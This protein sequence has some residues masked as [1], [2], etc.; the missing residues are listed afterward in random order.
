[1]L[2]LTALNGRKAVAWL[3]VRKGADVVVKDKDR[4]TMLHFAAVWF[5]HIAVA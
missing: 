2:H 3:L 5:R 4:L 1:L